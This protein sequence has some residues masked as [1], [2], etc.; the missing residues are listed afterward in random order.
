M[1]TSVD[2]TVTTTTVVKTNKLKLWRVVLHNDDYTPMDFVIA[3]L[4][5][6]FYKTEQDAQFITDNIHHTGKGVAGVYTQEIAQ[7]KAA[8]TVK[9]ARANKHPLMATAE[10][11]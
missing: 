11:V 3:I 2:T 4:V 5:R 10:Q 6:F 1:T 7:Q 9:V 8:D